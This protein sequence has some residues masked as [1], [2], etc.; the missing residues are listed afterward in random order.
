MIILLSNIGAIEISLSKFYLS[1]GDVTKHFLKW[2]AS[3]FILHL[4]NKI[5]HRTH[6]KYLNINTLSL[7]FLSSPV[8]HKWKFHIV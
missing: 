4:V 7:G 1:T 6:E 8:K 5:E 2:Y 3:L